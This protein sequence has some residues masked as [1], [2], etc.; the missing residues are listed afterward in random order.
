MGF[1]PVRQSWLNI[2]KSTNVIH[3][4]NRLKKKKYVVNAEKYNKIKYPF[5]IKIV[6]KLRIEEKFLNHI[7]PTINSTLNG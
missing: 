7:K 1:I 5:V 6:S 4:I 2:K 3:H